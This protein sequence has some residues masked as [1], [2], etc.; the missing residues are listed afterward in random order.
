MLP[1]MWLLTSTMMIG[2]LWPACGSD[3]ALAIFRARSYGLSVDAISLRRR[4]VALPWR[5]E[6]CARYIALLRASWWQSHP[7][8]AKHIGEDNDFVSQ[9]AAVGQLSVADAVDLMW[10]TIHHGNTS[11]RDTSGTNW[12]RI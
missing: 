12:E 9:A 3:S 6:V 4:R 8:T 1:A 7:F 2:A 5:T 10:A 11:P